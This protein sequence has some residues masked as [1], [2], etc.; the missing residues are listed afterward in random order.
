MAGL[1]LALSAFAQQA[2]SKK[3]GGDRGVMLNAESASV[4]RDIS[5]GLPTSDG[6]ASICEDGIKHSYSFVKGRYH[7]AGGN[8]YSSSRLRSLA[9]SI[10]KTGDIG[11]VLES[12]TKTGGDKLEGAFSF[13]TSTFGQINFDGAV[14][15]PIRKGWYYSVGAFVNLDPTSVNAPGRTFVDNRQI[16]K[17]ALTKRWNNAEF[18]IFYK[19]SLLY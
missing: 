1:V 2:E 17:A 16:F 8:A 10:I 7:W 6:G 5:I 15:G 4:P 14:S 19:F 9:E 11:I 13:K 3:E 12:T 18:N